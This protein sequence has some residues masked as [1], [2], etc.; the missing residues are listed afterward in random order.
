MC[1][2]PPHRKTVLVSVLALLCLVLRRGPAHA[3]PSLEQIR[4]SI[5]RAERQGARVGV[6]IKDLSTGQVL[7]RYNQ[8]RRFLSASVLKLGVLGTIYWLH[9]HKGLPLTPARL[10]EMQEMIGVSDNGAADRLV[11]QC[12][13]ARIN[14]FLAAQLG[15]HQTRLTHG[16]SH[17]GGGAN[18]TTPYEAVRQLE[19]LLLD[20][21][22]AR[23]Q[24]QIREF[25]T[26]ARWHDPTRLVRYIGADMDCYRKTGTQARVLNDVAYCENPNN[27]H[28]LI[29]S[30]L[31]WH[32]SQET[33]LL[34]SE[35][36]SRYLAAKLAQTPPA[37][38]R[39]AG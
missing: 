38:K 26:V 12:G 29:A 28:R 30:F 3:A 18:V 22:L 35:Q 4:A 19:Y 14:W 37:Q 27:V 7:F 1:L 39:L 23:F 20:P 8:D 9:R 33:N 17:G 11:S 32:G 25:L 36:I 24:P 34:L 10:Q 6:Y 16:F 15:C 13:R 5:R 2:R 21:S 31:S